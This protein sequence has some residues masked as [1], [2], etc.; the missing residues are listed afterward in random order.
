M[1]LMGQEFHGI[2]RFTQIKEMN[3][4]NLCLDQRKSALLAS[5]SLFL[6]AFIREY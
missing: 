2:N 4:L 1:D 6:S 5:K 3:L